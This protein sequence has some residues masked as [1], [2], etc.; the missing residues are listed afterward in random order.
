[1]VRSTD[2]SSVAYALACL[3]VAGLPAVSFPHC[4]TM[5][6]PVAKDARVALDRGDDAA[7]PPVAGCMT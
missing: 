6:G 7:Q 1:M 4:D 5:D 2:R 3:I